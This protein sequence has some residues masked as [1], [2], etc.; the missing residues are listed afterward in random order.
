MSTKSKK[1]RFLSLFIDYASAISLIAL[2]FLFWHLGKGPVE[3]NFLRPYITQ[4]LTNETSS[5]ELSIGAV[6]L[7]LVHSVQPVRVSASDVKFIDNDGEYVVHAPRLALDFSARALLKGMLAPSSIEIDNPKIDIVAKYG[8]ETSS[9]EAKDQDIKDINLKKLEFYFAQF[10]DF[11]ERFNSPDKMY[12]E[13]FINEIKISNGTVVI[14]EVD[15]NRK[16]KLV[17]ADFLFER[18]LTDILLKTESAIEFGNRTAAI[19][20]GLKYN[21]FNDDVKYTLGFSD[22]V[23]TDLYDVFVRDKKAVR[24][25]DIPV[26][27]RL[28]A[29]IDFAQVLKDKD[30]FAENLGKNIEE[31]TFSIDGGKGS[32]GFGQSEEFDYDVSSFSFN[33]QLTG[34]LDKVKIEDAVFDFGDKQAKLGLRVEG[35]KDYFF[36]GDLDDLKITFNADLGNF[37]LDELSKLWP[38]YLGEKAWEWC[39]EGLYGGEISNGQFV[40][41]FGYDEE[42]KSFGLTRLYGTADVEDANLYYLEGMPVITNLYGRAIFEQDKIIIN[43]DKGVSDGVIL[44]GGQ[45]VLYDLNKD[46]NFIKIDLT[47]NSTITNALKLIDHDPLNFTR[48]MGVNPD[49]VAGDVDIGLK[50][51]FELKSNLKPSE[52]KVGVVGDLSHVEYLGLKSGKTFVADSLKLN[53]TEKGYELT[54]VAKYDG[55]PLDLKI[56]D[57][58]HDDKSNSKVVANVKI[59]NEIL[60]KLGVESELLQAPY[61]VGETDVNAVLDFL[62]NGEI[63]LFVDAS[64]KDVAMDYAFL[65]FVKNVGQPA[66]AKVRMLIADNKI[67]DISDFSVIKAQFNAKGNMKMYDDG[68]LKLIDVTEIKAP[69]TFAKAKINFGYKPKI[70]LKVTVTGDS[71]DLTEFFDFR[72]NDTKEKK[73]QKKSLKDPLEDLMDMEIVVGVNKLWTNKDVPISNFAGKLVIKNG[74]GLHLLSLIGNYGSSNDVKMKLDFAPRGDEY[75]LTVDSNN[76]GSTLKVLRLYDNMRGGNLRIEAKRDKYKNIR[77]HAKMWDFALVNPPVFAKVLSL[78]S[79]RGIVDMLSGEGLTFSHFNAP[80]SYTFSTK[81]LATDGA[82][83]VGSVLGATMSGEYNLVDGDISAKGMVIPAYGLNKF[84]GNIPLVGKVLAGKDGTVFGTNFA[85]SGSVD[86]P[87][88]SINTLSTLAPNSVKELFSGE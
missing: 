38:K 49:Q 58:F 15:M 5:Y 24:A 42:S 57:N 33:G 23:I 4:A 40:F 28:T 27:G 8:L 65:G 10:E 30:K 81:Y 13:S 86:K 50:L 72:K 14:D 7:E 17:G 62:K 79:F 77:G 51:D 67:K 75:M 46:D 31:V 68:S 85:I 32:I 16:V 34:E 36:K 48:E 76:A 82:R 12:L 44:T 63:D 87:D 47:G 21:I 3:V 53:V 35:F 22:L 11:M 60:K 84:I 80:F 61:F 52:I 73:K 18:R 25:V 19:D 2:L 26:N 56:S 69:K 70:N 20:M 88:V 55:I 6:N 74:I 9:D 45:V 66:R 39:K 1:L 83:L 71:Y 41:D 64:L 29:M 37:N 59:N 78:A 43:A 54:G